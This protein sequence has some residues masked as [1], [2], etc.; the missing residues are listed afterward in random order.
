MERRNS[1]ARVLSEMELHIAH[2]TVVPAR[3][4]SLEITQRY[5]MM[6]SLAGAETVALNSP[7]TPP[8][9]VA[10]VER[11]GVCSVCLFRKLPHFHHQ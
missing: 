8:P 6:A 1:L 10:G 7:K 5:L 2:P 9:P 11:G 3:V 4:V